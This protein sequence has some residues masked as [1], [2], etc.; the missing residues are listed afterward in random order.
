MAEEIKDL[1]Q[2]LEDTYR[3]RDYYLKQFDEKT[4]KLDELQKELTEAK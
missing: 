4:A 2:E 3:D 1:K